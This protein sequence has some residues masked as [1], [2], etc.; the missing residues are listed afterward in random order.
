MRRSDSLGSV[1]LRDIARPFELRAKTDNELIIEGY[2][3]VFDAPYEVNDFFGAYTEIMDPKAFNKT[4]SAKP[5]LQLL[6]NHGGEPLARTK[7]GTLELSADDVGL[8]VWASLDRTDPD[9][10]RLEPKLLRRD[11][12]EMSFAFRA[13]RQE[14]N[15]D[16]TERRLL[17]VNIH[18]GDVSVVNYGA[19]PATS[20][21]VQRALQA[22]AAG[23]QEALAEVRNSNVDMYALQRN[24]R[25]ARPQTTGPKLLTVT[26]IYEMP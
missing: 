23:D 15:E 24:L 21:A 20:V 17:E 10:Q 9:V 1:Q 12:D 25:A 5:D 4:L 8:K 3:S 2:A 7:S 19:N 22:I 26:A 11:M 6:V 16:E 13:V 14:W 18:K